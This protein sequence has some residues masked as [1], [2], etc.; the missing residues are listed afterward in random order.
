MPLL[1]PCRAGL[2]ISPRSIS[3]TIR[4]PRPPP[5]SSRLDPAGQA[6]RIRARAILW[7]GPTPLLPCSFE[8][9]A[10]LCRSVAIPSRSHKASPDPTRPH[11]IPQ[12]PTRSH[13]APPDPT[14]EPLDPTRAPPDPIK[15]PARSHQVPLDPASRSHFRIPLPDPTS[16]SH[17]WIPH[18]DP[19]CGSH[20]RIPLPDPTCGSHLRQSHLPRRHSPHQ[21]SVGISWRGRHRGFSARSPSPRGARVKGLRAGRRRGSSS[22]VRA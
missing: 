20:M 2:R 16:G 11:Q 15:G 5:S 19:T 7:S 12:G 14:K 4:C 13:K 10:H 3:R 6:S 17:F 1:S 8:H 9:P 21:L 22:L 18:A